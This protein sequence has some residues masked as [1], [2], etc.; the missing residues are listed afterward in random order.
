MKLNHPNIAFLDATKAML[1]F[2]RFSTV[3]LLFI[4]L[5]NSLFALNIFAM[6]FKWELALFKKAVAVV[7][8]PLETEGETGSASASLRRDKEVKA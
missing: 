7:T 8:A 2:F 4:L 6:T 5:G 1:V 3:G